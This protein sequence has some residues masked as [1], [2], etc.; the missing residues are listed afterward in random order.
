MSQTEHPYKRGF[1][2]HPETLIEGARK[3][4]QSDEV[5]DQ[6]LASEMVDGLERAIID[7]D[8][9][10]EYVWAKELVDL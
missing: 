2:L 10:I 7:E 1:E 9:D 8:S 3:L 6:Y 5:Y 4:Q